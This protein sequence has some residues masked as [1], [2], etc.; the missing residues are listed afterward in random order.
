M[1]MGR[2]ETGRAQAFL[3]GVAVATST[4][5]GIEVPRDLLSQVQDE[6]G[7][8]Q[9][10]ALGPPEQMRRAE[11]EPTAAVDELLKI[12]MEYWRRIAVLLDNGQLGRKETC[13][14]LR[15]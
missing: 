6:L 15:K 4:V 9:G 2:V 5:L 1:Y 14:D 13:D 7:W 8:G 10:G 12:E 3:V 11:L